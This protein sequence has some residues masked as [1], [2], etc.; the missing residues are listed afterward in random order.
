MRENRH[1]KNFTEIDGTRIYHIL[2]FK[3]QIDL[4]FKFAKFCG[5]GKTKYYRFQILFNS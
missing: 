2:I 3:D 1:L 5:A 4:A